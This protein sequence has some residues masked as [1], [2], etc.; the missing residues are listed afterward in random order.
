VREE[1]V[2]GS[3][4]AREGRGEGIGRIGYECDFWR[5]ARAHAATALRRS[6]KVDMPSPMVKKTH[7]EDG[8]TNAGQRPAAPG[9]YVVLARKYRPSAFP[10][11]IGQEAMV[12]TLTN[13]FA[14]GR[15][16]QAYMLT[17][18][19][20][21]GKT[22]T[23]RILARALNYSVPGKV[24]AP[25]T[26]MPVLGEH[27]QAIIESRHADVLEM[28]A[29]SN[30][31]IDNVREIIE[32]ARYRPILARTKVY[33]IDEVHMLSKGAFNALLKTLEEPPEHAKFIFATTEIRKV[34]VTVLSRCQRFD[35][36]RVDVSVLAQHFQG[37]A[38]QEGIAVDADALTLIARAAEGSVRDG[39]SVLDQAFATA[40]GTVT[41]ALVRQM[42]GV[43][44]RGRIFDLLE[45]LLGGD[46]KAALDSFEMLHKDSADPIQVLG[47]LAEAVHAV[48]RARVGGAAAAGDALSSEEAARAHGLAAKLG[49]GLLSRAFAMLL[50]GIEEAG[51]APNAF[52]AAEM[53]LV[54]L[55]YMADLPAPDDLLRRLTDGTAALGATPAASLAK[56]ALPVANAAPASSPPPWEAQAKPKLA[57]TKPTIVPVPP[58]SLPP[59]GVPAAPQ[60]TTFPDLV[61]FVGAK[62][63]VL[64]RTELEE[65]VRLVRFEPPR[66][67]VNLL[68]GADPGLLTDLSQ[69]LTKWTGVRWM[70]AVS[71]EPGDPPL[72]EAIRAREAD[73]LARTRDNPAVRD[74]IARFP[75]AEITAVRPLAVE[76]AIA[77]ETT[78][79]DEPPPA[80]FPDDGEF[81]PY[82]DYGD[83]SK[84]M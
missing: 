6:A 37:I 38:A 84:A 39:L 10:D 9:P 61:A 70:I 54:R 41:A 53:V 36:R 50:K 67:E 51:R 30:T 34:P 32:N 68:P 13:A 83:D 16:A 12:R 71:R 74:L 81:V 5:K 47:D 15:I 11:L 52:M 75:G 73:A 48:T 23:A 82:D 28:D 18:V 25:T 60:F 42:L 8:T 59:T 2:P 22:T 69:K 63:D 49:I 45:V 55:A 57:P 43:A 26:D 40:S 33:I 4:S 66:L 62:R 24:D 77:A 19:R 31:G 20:G 1:A 79:V 35:L 78:T 64:L 56:P 7:N 27:C 80:D 72:I 17:G 29:A 21:V 44:D 14:T 58:A 3:P 76:P 65:R 46:A